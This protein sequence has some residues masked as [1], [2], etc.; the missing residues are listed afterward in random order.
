[1]ST[2]LSWMRMSPWLP[3]MRMGD[4][5]GGL[6]FH[7]RGYKLASYEQVPERTRAYV[8]ANHPEYAH[9]PEQW[10]EPNES[11]WTYFRKLVESGRSSRQSPQ[12]SW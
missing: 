6:V 11:S 5:P 3:W 9:A 1:M 8:A 7:C 2:V 12:E 10:T 4:R